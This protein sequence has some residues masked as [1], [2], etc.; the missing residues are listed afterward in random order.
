MNSQNVILRAV[1]IVPVTIL[2]LVVLGHPKSSSFVE[3]IRQKGFAG[4]GD[5]GLSTGMQDWRALSWA[6]KERRLSLAIA[7]FREQKNCAILKS[8]GHYVVLVDRLF[9]AAPAVQD[10]DLLTLLH[11]LAVQE[12]DFYSGVSADEQALQLL[13]PEL[14]RKNL[15]ARRAEETRIRPVGVKK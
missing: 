3:T 2:C 11:G 13:G 12:Y 1:A 15:E 14:F 7:Y 8:A 9:Q 6:E 5:A 10:K 4:L